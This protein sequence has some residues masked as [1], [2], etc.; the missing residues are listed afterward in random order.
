MIS[1]ALVRMVQPLR[2]MFVCYGVLFLF[3]FAAAQQTQHAPEVY[4]GKIMAL[5]GLLAGKPTDL[6]VVI[7]RAST[8]EE[9]HKYEAILC[10]P[11]GQ[12]LLADTIGNSY[13]IGAYRIG[14]ELALA[15]K[16]ITIRET[17]KGRQLF[18]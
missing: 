11:D 2:S 16:I 7:G 6:A 12:T 17:E 4:T 3:T 1:P 10:K 9:L 15:V 13:D 5:S 14:T 18:L 8:D